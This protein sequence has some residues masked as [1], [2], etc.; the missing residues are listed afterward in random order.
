[1]LL[2]ALVVPGRARSLLPFLSVVRFFSTP[3]LFVA[4]PLREMASVDKHESPLD[5]DAPGQPIS[6][7]DSGDTGESGKL[8]MIVQLVKKCLGVK[9][10]AAMYVPMHP[11][12][13]GLRHHSIEQAFVPPRITA[14]TDPK[15]RVLALLG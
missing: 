8:K 5:E 9:D 11:P 1:M 2:R 3:S 6:V 7:P 14:R 13:A 12:S 4:L 10:I 15:S